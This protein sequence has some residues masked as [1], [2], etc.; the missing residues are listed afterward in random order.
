MGTTPRVET[1]KR[2]RK[3]GP[4]GQGLNRQISG[5]MH[6][7]PELQNGW[8]EIPHHRVL[9]DESMVGRPKEG[10]SKKYLK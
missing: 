8:H 2:K 4:G 9:N 7:Q 6:G 3:E 10:T 5:E 1:L